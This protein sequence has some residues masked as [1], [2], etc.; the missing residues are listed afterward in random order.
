MSG[1]DQMIWEDICN[2]NVDSLR[3]LHDRYYLQ[4]CSYARRYVN[5][6]IHVE[7]LVSD[8]FVKLWVHRKNIMIEKSIKSYVFLMLR[9]RIVDEARKSESNIVLS[10]ESLPDIPDEAVINKSDFYAELYGAIQR[11]PEQRK[12]I[13]ELAAFE[14]YTY[15]EI[16]SEL[17]ISVNTVK[18]QMSRAYKFLKEELD[19]NSFLFLYLRVKKDNKL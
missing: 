16:A 1:N 5:N 7:E 9:N 4:L 10:S 17:S 14:S 18:T 12:K 2:G 11:L 13:L 3:I 19:P 15:K 6:S 8:C